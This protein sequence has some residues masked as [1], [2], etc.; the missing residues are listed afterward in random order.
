MRPLSVPLKKTPK[1]YYIA[2]QRTFHY[3]LFNCCFILGIKDVKYDVT[4]RGIITS[5]EQE[6]KTQNI[7]GCGNAIS[8]SAAFGIISHDSKPS[9][10]AW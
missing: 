9:Q 10:P 8:H 5:G 7:S 1:L 3:L 6:K 2:H 4:T